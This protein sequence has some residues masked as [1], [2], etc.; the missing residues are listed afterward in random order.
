MK[1][2][3]YN[4]TIKALRDCQPNLEFGVKKNGFTIFKRQEKVPTDWRPWKDMYVG[5]ID[6]YDEQGHSGYRMIDIYP[7]IY[8]TMKVVP[9]RLAKTETLT[10]MERMFQLCAGLEDLDVL[11]NFDTS[12]ATSMEYMFLCCESVKNINF[13]KFNTS[14][15]TNMADM[16]QGCASLE[17]L[18][19]SM[20]DVSKVTAMN[21]MFSGCTNLKSINLST[22]NTS[23]ISAGGCDFACM[24]N[25]CKALRTID[26]SG[27]DTAKAPDLNGMF[28]WCY[29]LETITGVID[30]ASVKNDINKYRD[31]F[32]GCTKLKGVKIRNKPDKFDQYSGLTTSQYQVVA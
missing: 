12:N 10:T 19:L 23:S 29:D 4:V 9:N 21:N 16:F 27:F 6:S 30:F 3:K 17:T 11:E 24:F 5:N 15:V 32:K 13:S 2:K 1:R 22:W 31:I 20:F 18:D 14:K 26:I 7:D 28:Y 25:C 8:Y